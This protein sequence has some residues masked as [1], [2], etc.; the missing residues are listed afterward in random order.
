MRL[1]RMSLLGIP[2]SDSNVRGSMLGLLVRF[3][4]RETELGVSYVCTSRPQEGRESLS[5]ARLA[6]QVDSPS[7]SFCIARPGAFLNGES[8][9]ASSRA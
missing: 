5:S 7:S 9:S 6:S 8:T 1:R 2:Q 3:R 4:Y